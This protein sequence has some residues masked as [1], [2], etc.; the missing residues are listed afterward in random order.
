MT[1]RDWLHFCAALGHAV[2]GVVCLSRRGQS[3]LS[4]LLGLLCLDLFGVNFATLAFRSSHAAGWDWTDAVFTALCPAL[5]LHFV[6]TF[7]GARR[8]HARFVFVGYVSFGTLALTSFSAFL[9]PW[10]RAWGRYGQ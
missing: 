8:R 10:G 6:V 2:L 7:V 1:A 3:P 4:R 9:S 5:V